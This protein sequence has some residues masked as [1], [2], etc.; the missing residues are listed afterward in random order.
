M[1]KSRHILFLFMFDLAYNF[2][3]IL[4]NSAV[5]L[6][7]I[8]LYT[9]FASTRITKYNP[10]RVTPVHFCHI[11]IRAKPFP[12]ISFSKQDGTKLHLIISHICNYAK[13]KMQI[14]QLKIAKKRKQYKKKSNKKVHNYC[15]WFF[16]WMYRNQPWYVSC[17]QQHEH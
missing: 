14:C 11:F 15:I 16:L 9:I 4:V 13:Y 1:F 5:E 10:T 12:L 17:W 3:H 6:F 7:K 2:P 8:W